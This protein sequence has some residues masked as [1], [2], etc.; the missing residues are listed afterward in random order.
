MFK[1]GMSETHTGEVNIPEEDPDTVSALLDMTIYHK[2][3]RSLTG[4]PDENK[5]FTLLWDPVAVYSLAEMWMFPLEVLDDIMDQIIDHHIRAEELPSLDFADAAFDKTP[6]GSKLRDYAVRGIV[7]ALHHGPKLGDIGWPADEVQKLITAYPDFGTQYVA[8][9][10][11]GSVEPIT[12][13]RYCFNEPCKF[14]AHAPQ[15]G[16]CHPVMMA[17]QAGSYRKRS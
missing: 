4:P 13:P 5:S 12:D 14:H 3:I 7:Y 1:I 10:Q 2:G 6:E 16:C 17:K 8:L 11:V 15:K 9:N